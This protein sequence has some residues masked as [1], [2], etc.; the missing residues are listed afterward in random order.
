MVWVF[1]LS[2]GWLLRSCSQ[3]WRLPPWR[4]VCVRPCI[5]EEIWEAVNLPAQSWPYKTGLAQTSR[6]LYWLSP[7]SD[8]GCCK[9][10]E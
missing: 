9:N 6:F 5:W 8:V 4:L 10:K 2:E 3:G 1:G 7:D